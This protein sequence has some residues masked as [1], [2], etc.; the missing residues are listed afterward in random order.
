MIAFTSSIKRLALCVVAMGLWTGLESRS[1]LADEANAPSSEGQWLTS[2]P[3]AKA[4]AKK[5]NKLIL[6]DFTGSDWCPW[7]IKLK[8]DVLSKPA[9]I[10]YAK[11][12]LVLVE[13]DFPHEK[14]QADSLK[15]ANKA[16]SD[17]YSVSGL[18]TLIAM[19]PDGKVVWTQPGYLEGG[20]SAVIAKLDEAKSK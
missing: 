5:E 3:E 8:S 14:T 2:L 9:F 11:K 17:K 20:P 15:E 4:L 1:A 18:P 7:C 6:L 12:N 13:V 16:L 19:K 10:N